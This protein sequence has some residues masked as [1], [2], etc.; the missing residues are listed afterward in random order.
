MYS[1]TSGCTGQEI[2]PIAIHRTV[3]TA[4]RTDTELRGRATA[5]GYGAPFLRFIRGVILRSEFSHMCGG[6]ATIS[7]LFF[8]LFTRRPYM[9]TAV[10]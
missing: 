7:Y 5:I 9:K 2:G 4:S 1:I 6:H 3:S 10:C 8:S